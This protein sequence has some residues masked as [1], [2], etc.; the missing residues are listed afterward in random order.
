VGDDVSDAQADH[1]DGQSAKP[2]LLVDGDDVAVAV[3]PQH[4]EGARPQHP[5]D[6]APPR[7]VRESRAFVD[8]VGS[9]DRP[10][11]PQRL[12]LLVEPVDELDAR[13]GAQLLKD[14]M[15]PGVGRI[16][17]PGAVLLFVF[18]RG[19]AGASP[20][21]TGVAFRRR[22]R[23]GTGPPATIVKCTASGNVGSADV[24]STRR[25]IV[26]RATLA[27]SIAK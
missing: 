27:S 20:S 15:V 18:Q 5:D 22:T 12:T 16:E 10:Q 13:V 25:M 7:V 8:D 11:L 19:H 2:L 6:H 9:R 1:A 14:A 3:E 26:A 4:P 23:A 21:D 24:T 17:K